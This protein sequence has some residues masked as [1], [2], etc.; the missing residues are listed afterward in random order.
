MEVSRQEYWS[1]LPC[2]PPGDFLDPGIELASPVAPEL[3]GGFFTADSPGKLINW[4]SHYGQQYVCVCVKLLQS[5]PTL[6]DPMD[7]G[8]RLLCPWEGDD[9]PFSRGSF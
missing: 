1:G 5:C 4:Y 7:R 2:L 9:I 3:A 8:A 6:G